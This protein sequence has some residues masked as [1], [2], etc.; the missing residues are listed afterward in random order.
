MTAFALYE[1]VE[2]VRWK[3][4]AVIRYRVVDDD[5]NRASYADLIGQTFGRAPAYAHV[6]EEREPF[7]F[8]CADCGA[9]AAIHGVLAPAGITAAMGPVGFEEI[10][11][12][13]SEPEVKGR[14][15][16]PR[17]AMF[18]ADCTA[19]RTAGAEVRR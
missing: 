6:V 8:D 17:S 5:F 15:R 3:A 4:G 19:Q 18:C 14:R 11:I 10:G 7:Y 1:L 12:L 2:P 9:D 16:G 13:T